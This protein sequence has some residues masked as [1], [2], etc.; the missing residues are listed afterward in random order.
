[1]SDALGEFAS[2]TC[3]E[4]LWGFVVGWTMLRLRR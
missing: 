2:I 1:M 4:L 3:A